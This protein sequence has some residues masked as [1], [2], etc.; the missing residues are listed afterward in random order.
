MIGPNTLEDAE[1]REMLH[2]DIESLGM[3]QLCVYA[4]YVLLQ[5]QILEHCCVGYL[6]SKMISKPR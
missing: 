1:S 5:S 2:I 4:R 3:G 6:P